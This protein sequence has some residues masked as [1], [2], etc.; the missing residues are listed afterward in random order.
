[1]EPSGERVREIPFSS[2]RK[3]MTVVQ[4]HEGET[5]AYMK[6]APE[7]VVQRCDRVLE[8]GE[9]VEMTEER[10]EEI[11]ERNAAFAGDALR[12]L[13]FARKEAGD[14]DADADD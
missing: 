14:V 4:E 2:E 11:L 6:G 13:G 1:V 12:V 5:T 8:D 9:V 10:R 7:T 3:R